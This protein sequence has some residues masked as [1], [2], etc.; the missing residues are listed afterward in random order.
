[1]NKEIKEKWVTAL[2]SGEYKQAVHFLRAT[3]DNEKQ[4][5]GYCCLGVLCDLYIKEKN[6]PNI[7]WDVTAFGT[8]I[9]SH[10]IDDSIPIHESKALP[11]EL[12]LWA[13]LNEKNPGISDI[14]SSLAELNDK[15]KTFEEIATIIEEKF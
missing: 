10:S 12:L 9:F 15:G 7:I 3:I 4:T 11:E 8:H 14:N 6:D 5:I 1:M 2:R 13:D